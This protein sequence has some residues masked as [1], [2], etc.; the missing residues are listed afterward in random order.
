MSLMLTERQRLILDGII[1]QY[2]DSARPVS[3]KLIER[4]CGLN[5]SPATIRNEMQELSDM[6]YISQP[7]TSAGRVPTDKGYRFL[8]DT[9][10]E[11]LVLQENEQCPLTFREE[12]PLSTLKRI[13]ADLSKRCSGLAI[14]FLEDQ[15]IFWKEGMKMVFKEPEF[16][17]PEYSVRFINCLDLLEKRFEYLSE[18]IEGGIEVYIG[19]ESPLYNQDDFS[20]IVSRHSE[21][22]FLAIFGPKRMRYKEN[23]KS[24]INIHGN[25]KRAGKM[26]KTKRR[27]S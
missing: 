12:S 19:R 8:I 24:L 21:N 26:P 13:S 15:G 10:L 3:S 23:I 27:I 22:L 4:V 16:R 5:V 17:Q 2:I 18:N 20:L 6:G 7:H 11:E 1:N 25:R 14:A 9:I